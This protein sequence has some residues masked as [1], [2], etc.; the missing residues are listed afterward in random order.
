MSH[1]IFARLD[2][3]DR[4]LFRRLSTAEHATRAS[5]AFWI[6]LTHLGGARVTIAATLL[7]LLFARA[8]AALAA[9]QALATLIISHLI[10]QLIKRNVGRPRPSCSE[11][12]CAL[13][14][15]PDRFSFPSGHAA[16]AMSIALVYALAFPAVAAVLVPL[17]VLIG[18]SRVVLGVHYPGDVFIGQLIAALTAVAIVIG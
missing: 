11:I 3:R 12:T 13:V 14:A 6:S 16:A 18:M 8:A 5:R 9:R 17:A 7:P 15:E 10:V 1:M 2:A 4:A